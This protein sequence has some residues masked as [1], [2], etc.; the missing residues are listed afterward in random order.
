MTDGKNTNNEKS[1]FPIKYAKNS[2]ISAKNALEKLL[3]QM[4]NLSQMKD[5]HGFF[6][7]SCYKLN[8]SKIF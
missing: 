2:Q 6:C 5:P 1:A 3:K 8:G 7:K 4:L